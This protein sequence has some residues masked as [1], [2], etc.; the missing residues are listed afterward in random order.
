MKELLQSRVVHAHQSG[1]LEAIQSTCEFCLELSD[2][3]DTRFR[4]IYRG[5]R[6]RIVVRINRIAVMPTL[7]Q[8][9]M[10]SLLVLP[11]FHC[12]TAADLPPDDRRDLLDV[13]DLMK[14]KVQ[15]VGFPLVVEHGVRQ[16]SGTGCGIYHAHI[17]V[18]PLPEH[19]PFRELLADAAKP[20][21]SLNEALSYRR[22]QAKSP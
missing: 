5:R 18:I 2:A 11:E 3:P 15:K 14:D 20:T 10:G 12:E 16:G 1:A 8:L 22:R 6:D 4:S 13:V 19:L 21:S 9:F 7:G 17:H